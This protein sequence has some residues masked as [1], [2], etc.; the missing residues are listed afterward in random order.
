MTARNARGIDIVAYNENATR[1]LGIQVK[2]LRRPNA[3]GK[4]RSDHII[5]DFWIIVENAISLSPTCFVLTASEV[6]SL[7]IQNA[8]K[9]QVWLE[10]RDYRKDNFREAWARIGDG[11]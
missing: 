8:H 4:L 6:K 7:A 9:R 10:K 11:F 1:M 2:S 5:G 3:A